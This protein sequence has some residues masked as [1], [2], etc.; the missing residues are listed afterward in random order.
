MEPRTCE[1]D[2]PVCDHPSQQLVSS[3][4]LGSVVECPHWKSQFEITGTI[5]LNGKVSAEFKKM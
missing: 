3:L 4:L 2:C 1:F 5:R